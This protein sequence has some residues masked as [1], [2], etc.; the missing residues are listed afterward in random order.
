LP[1]GI[2]SPAFL[3][4]VARQ[5]YVH[6]VRELTDTERSV[7]ALLMSGHTKAEAAR[8]LGVVPSSVT[9]AMDR[10]RKHLVE[11]GLDPKADFPRKE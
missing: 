1:D 9:R 8:I 2:S 5:E 11:A 3:A 7:C 10:V 4:P 6:G